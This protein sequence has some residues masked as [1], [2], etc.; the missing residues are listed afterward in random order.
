MSERHHIYLIPGFFGFADLGGITYFHH[1]REFLTSELERFGLEVEVLPV[2]TLPTS[3]IRKRTASL[4]ETVTQTAGDGGPI[5]LVGHSTGGLDARLFAAPSTLLDETEHDLMAMAERVASVVTVATPHR[6]TPMASF[7]ASMMGAK[8]LYLLSLGTIYTLRFG[9]M[10]LSVAVKL[11]GI[12]AR[13]DDVVGLENNV[14]DQLYDQLFEDFDEEREAAIRT[15]LENVRND[16]AL[17]GQ[18]TAG[19]IDLFN[20]STQNREGVRYGS[21]VIQARRP[22]LRSIKNVGLDPYHQSTHALYRFLHWLSSRGGDEL[23]LNEEHASALTR[24]F[25]ELPGP[26]TSDGIVPTLS[27]PWGT[28]IHTATADHLD[29]CGHFD[30]PSHEPPH[31]DW[32]ATGSRFDRRKFEALW[33]KVAMHISEGHR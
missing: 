16:Q 26:E 11:G 20:A 21:V 19:G 27:Q 2:S 28:V 32:I 17:V 33:R 30:D 29:V 15:F 14:L 24:G 23:G 4:L 31:V 7:F 10:P 8:L 9:K 3:S 22:G 5:H 18:L 13:L 6:G 12:L 25:G 1:V